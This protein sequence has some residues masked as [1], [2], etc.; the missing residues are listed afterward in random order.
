MLFHVT[1]DFIDP[2][3]ASERRHVALFAE[4]QPPV[5][6]DF[7]AFYVYPDYS[8]GLAIVDVDSTAT[9]ARTMAP[10]LPWLRFTARPIE[11]VTQTMAIRLEAMAFRDSVAPVADPVL[12]A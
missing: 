2:T 11:P 10:W 6:A 1:W 4:W 3:E 12:A 8:G 9:L 7:Q 5:E